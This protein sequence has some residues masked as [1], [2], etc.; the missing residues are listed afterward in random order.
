MRTVKRRGRPPQ[1]NSAGEN[2]RQ[3]IVDAAMFCFQE[4][5]VAMTRSSDIALKA[6]VDQPLINYYFP[7]VEALHIEVI[8][9]VARRIVSYMSER[10][11][12]ESGGLAVLREYVF[13]YF[14]FQRREPELFSLWLYFYYLTGRDE[15]SR[16]KNEEFRR[17]GRERV[18]LM[19]YRLLEEG[20]LPPPSRGELSIPELSEQIIGIISGNVLLAATES[21]LDSRKLAERT[22][23]TIRKFASVRS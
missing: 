16:N 14:E 2:S 13:S 9:Q 15:A 5:G 3:R 23:S 11:G 10:T 1:K 8:D 21:K 18:S 19:L 7:R 20:L 6:G 22:W 17:A 4:R 12:K